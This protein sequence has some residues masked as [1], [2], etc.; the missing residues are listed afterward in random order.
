MELQFVDQRV[1]EARTRKG[2][3]AVLQRVGHAADAVVRFHQQ[4]LGHD[5][6]AG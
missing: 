6:G 3:V 4:V 2:Q 5:L 1:V